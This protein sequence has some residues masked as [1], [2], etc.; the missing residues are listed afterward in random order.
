MFNGGKLYIY[1]H[2]DNVEE[3]TIRAAMPGKANN[4]CRL[5]VE[6]ASAT[7]RNQGHLHVLSNLRGVRK[8]N[9][10]VAHSS[11]GSINFDNQFPG[12]LADYIVGQIV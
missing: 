5:G 11:R 4:L 9:V 7:G 3:R 12:I 8:I 10:K 2:D 1:L 6:L